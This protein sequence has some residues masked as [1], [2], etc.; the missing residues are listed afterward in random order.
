M[1]GISVAHVEDKVPS[2]TQEFPEYLK[3]KK[4]GNKNN[5]LPFQHHSAQ[6]GTPNIFAH[7]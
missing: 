2:P 7:R 6:R 5:D 4:R 1:G 3:H